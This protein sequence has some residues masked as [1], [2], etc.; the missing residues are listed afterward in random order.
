MLS[1]Q[2][3]QVKDSISTISLNEVNFEGISFE[4]DSQISNNNLEKE[5]K[6]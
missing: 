5:E 6:N 4:P 2:K 1:A 3:V